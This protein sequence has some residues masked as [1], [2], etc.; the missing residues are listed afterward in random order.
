MRKLMLAAALAL[1]TTASACTFMNPFGGP[2]L[3]LTGDLQADLPGIHAYAASIKAGIK[4]D[5]AV[6]KAK[7]QQ[8]CPKIKPLQDAL[9]SDPVQ[10]GVA[11]AIGADQAGAAIAASNEALEVGND[12]CGGVT[13]ADLQAAFLMV[14]QGIEDARALIALVPAVEAIL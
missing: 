4:A 5:A 6:V 12:F 2:P 11:K 1:A 7:F 8:L 3:A 9:I 14:V 10:A 13:A